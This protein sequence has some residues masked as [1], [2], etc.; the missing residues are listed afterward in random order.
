MTGIITDTA[1][2]VASVRKLVA[3]LA[4]QTHVIHSISMQMLLVQAFCAWSWEN[5]VNRLQ[6]G[7]LVIL[8]FL[9]RCEEFAGECG[10]CGVI[11]F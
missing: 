9:K 5:A 1:P 2:D 10:C 4:E 8:V 7:D 11:H 3:I 6:K